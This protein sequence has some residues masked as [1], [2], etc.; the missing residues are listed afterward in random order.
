MICLNIVRHCSV[1]AIFDETVNTVQ[2]NFTNIAGFGASVHIYSGISIK[3]QFEEQ[4]LV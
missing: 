1:Y 3:R 2:I 4:A